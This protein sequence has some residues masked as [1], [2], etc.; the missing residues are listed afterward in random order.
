[1][2][3]YKITWICILLIN[4]PLYYAEESNEDDSTERCS[5]TYN[6]VQNFGADINPNNVN[7]ISNFDQESFAD[8]KRRVEKIE[9][10][11]GLIAP[12][13]S[14]SKELLE[15]KSRGT[16]KGCKGLF[17]DGNCY[18]ALPEKA[19]NYSVAEKACSSYD[20]K[21][22]SVK[23]KAVHDKI[24]RYLWDAIPKMNRVN[25]QHVWLGAV[26]DPIVGGKTIQWSDDEKT[27]AIPHW[28]QSYPFTTANNKW[29]SEWTGIRLHIDDPRRVADTGL[30]NC[31]PSDSYIPLCMSSL[32]Y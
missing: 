15:D 12:D 24:Q 8:L 3:I 9:Q 7:P 22:A 19:L 4:L 27:R 29:Y 5:R 23:S 2:V 11:L 13:E 31:L 6:I 14:G 21:L 17:Y 20:A 25:V 30:S 32:N 16:D 18:F 26:Y 10:L 1:M 28:H